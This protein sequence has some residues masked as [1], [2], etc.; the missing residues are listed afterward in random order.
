MSMRWL[1][2]ALAAMVVGSLAGG[3]A[4]A[5]TLY[6]WETE[7][8]GIAFADDLKRIPERYRAKAEPVAMEG[9]S[10]YERYTPTDPNASKDYAERLAT[11]LEGLRAAAAEDEA[12]QAEP[13]ASAERRQAEPPSSIALE[14]VR[15]TV[16]RRRVRGP[17][18]L[19]VWRETRRLQSVREP[20]P[21]LGVQPDPDSDE[22]IVVEEIQVR[23]SDRFTRRATV[24]R[25]GDRILSIVKGPK[26][27]FSPRDFVDE[28]DLER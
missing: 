21:I 11:R 3:V 9:L 12:A 5:G 2:G 17:L 22:P 15:E 24:V 7:D 19:P 8:G 16:D 20:T 28:S 4:T 23:D 1:E 13:N 6:R 25:Q 26:H 27:H 14:S 18:G 10:A